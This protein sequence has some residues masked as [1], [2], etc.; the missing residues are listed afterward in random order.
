MYPAK[1]QNKFH[2]TAVRGWVTVGVATVTARPRHPPR[3]WPIFFNF[4]LHLPPEKEREGR[5]KWINKKEEAICNLS[6]HPGVSYSILSIR[7]TGE[8]QDINTGTQGEKREKENTA[9]DNVD[10]SCIISNMRNV[11]IGKLL[12]IQLFWNGWLRCYDLAVSW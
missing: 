12:C 3:K 11:L 6:L 5:E 2:E 7:F 8:E 1:W 4:L 9:T 10:V